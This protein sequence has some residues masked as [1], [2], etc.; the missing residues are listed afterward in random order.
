[1]FMPD[2]V[3]D[4]DRAGGVG[5]HVRQ[6]LPA[7]P[8]AGAV[9]PDE[10]VAHRGAPVGEARQHRAVVAL[11]VA[12]EL[13]AEL[14]D[15]LEAG[16][17]QPA[18]RGAVGGVVA[19]R[20]VLGAGI[21]DRL[22]DHQQLSQLLGEPAEVARAPRRREELVPHRV[23]QAG[24]QRSR[25][26]RVDVDPIALPPAPDGRVPLVDGDVNPCPAQALREAQATDAAPDDDHSPRPAHDCSPFA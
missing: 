8:G 10:D 5:V 6:V 7:N 17:Q 1:M 24:A 19:L 9:R 4:S 20:R 14:H 2:L 22:L 25:T 15:I 12:H 11:L 3:R 13:G 21:H 16:Q 23:G 18:Q 26:H